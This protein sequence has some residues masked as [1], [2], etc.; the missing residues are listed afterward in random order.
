MDGRRSFPSGHSST[1]FSGMTFLSLFLAG[2]TGAWLLSQAAPGRSMSSSRIT[3]LCITLSPL[4]FAVWVAV[5][6]VEDY[7]G[8]TQ[9]LLVRH[10][11]TGREPASPQGRCHSGQLV[12]H[13][14]CR[15]ML[16]HI[17]AESIHSNIIPGKQ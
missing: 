16:L 1:I 15:N 2:A 4:A 7:V 6:R 3:R 8:G 12:R 5:S 10:R 9:C 13:V 17:L 14:H 11:L